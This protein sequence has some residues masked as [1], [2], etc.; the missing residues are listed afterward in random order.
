MFEFDG[1]LA[2]EARVQNCWAPRASLVASPFSLRVEPG[3]TRQGAEA[4]PQGY[5]GALNNSHAL[6]QY[7]LI[8]PKYH[9]YRVFLGVSQRSHCTPL[10]RH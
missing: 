9:Y 10:F 4:Q 2:H 6:G 8:T 5:A 3:G 1:R 7:F